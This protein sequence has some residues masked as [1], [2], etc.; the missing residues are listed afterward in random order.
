M[1][2]FALPRWVNTAA[3]VGIALSVVPGL[4]SSCHTAQVAMK[5]GRAS[6][7]QLDAQKE[8]HGRWRVFYDDS[9]TQLAT[10]GR[11]RH[12]KPVGRWRYYSPKN[13]LARQERYRWWKTGRLLVKEFYPNGKIAKKGQAQIVREGDVV[14]FYWFG[15]WQEYAETGAPVSRAWYKMGQLQH[16]EPLP[17]K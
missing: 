1:N 6:R 16:R 13:S 15:P 4:L 11:Y 2:K 5:G 14:H 9:S 8:R 7:N 3:L 17:A 12:G 10:D